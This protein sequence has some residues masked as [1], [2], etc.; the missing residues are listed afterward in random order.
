MRIDGFRAVDV[1]VM[2]MMIMMIIICIIIFVF[3]YVLLGDALLGLFLVFLG[4]I[5]FVV[6]EV[7]F[8]L[9]FA[10]FFYLFIRCWIVGEDVWEGV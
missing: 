7:L 9:V 8:I 6:C 4:G 2:M 5:V 3:V 10:L 1:R